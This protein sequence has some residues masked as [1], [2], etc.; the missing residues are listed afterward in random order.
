MARVVGFWSEP[1]GLVDV[2]GR[3]AAVDAA[4]SPDRRNAS[5]IA[6]QALS[7]VATEGSVDAV[8]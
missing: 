5:L 1:E 3:G 8:G 2:F 4:P 6:R 7:V